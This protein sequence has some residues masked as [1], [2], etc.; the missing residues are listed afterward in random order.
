MLGCGH[1][2]F[3]SIFPKHPLQTMPRK[4]TCSQGPFL[5]LVQPAH[6][7]QPL[8]QGGTEAP[9]HL[10]QQRG[11][12]GCQSPRAAGCCLGMLYVVLPTNTD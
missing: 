2:L 10:W 3:P 1:T 6:T 12:S 4:R 5:D 9:F 11:L 7:V 8:L